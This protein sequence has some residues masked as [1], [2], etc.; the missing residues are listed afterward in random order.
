M[1][2]VDI[3]DSF[4]GSVDTK[5][6]IRIDWEELKGADLYEIEVADNQ[7]F[8]NP[9]V[10]QSE[11]ELNNTIVDVTKYQTTYYARVRGY[12]DESTSPWS[13]P[14]SFTTAVNSVEDVLASMDLKAY[15]NPFTET[16]TI[17]FNIIEAYPVKLE[18]YDMVGSKAYEK[19]LGT[20]GLG[21]VE[22]P[23]SGES[24]AAGTYYY[25]L[26]VGDSEKIG[27]MVLV[28]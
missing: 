16:I 10:T 25:K 21:R 27:E 18:V 14:C 15:P 6:K 24:L 28:K 4:C 13:D 8:L 1:D 17:S 26:I 7:S 22:I 19:D 23:V 5:L 12:N 2:K 3:L 20:P 11:I 9:E